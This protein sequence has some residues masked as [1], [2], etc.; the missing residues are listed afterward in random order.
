MGHTG[1]DFILP[2]AHAA[3]AVVSKRL[4]EDEFVSRHG[5]AAIAPEA[6]GT[7]IER[8]LS[9]RSIKSATD[10]AID[11]HRALGLGA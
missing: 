5:T 9:I 7:V 1:W 3:F 2:P 6:G 8:V 11:R 4:L 10:G